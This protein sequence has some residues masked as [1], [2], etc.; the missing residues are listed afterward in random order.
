MYDC[1]GIEISEGGGGAR[2]T[3]TESSRF[4]PLIPPSLRPFPPWC[5]V[6]Q[7]CCCY[8]TVEAACVRPSGFRETPYFPVPF[9]PLFWLL[10]PLLFVLGL[11]IIAD[12]LVLFLLNPRS[13]LAYLQLRRGGQEG[14]VNGTEG[15]SLL[16]LL[17]SSRIA[18]FLPFAAER[19]TS[20]SNAPPTSPPSTSTSSSVS[21][22]RARRRRHTVGARSSTFSTLSSP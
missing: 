10:L 20:P 18:H 3:K 1:S 4:D 8:N 9:Y 5:L 11:R 14:H 6:S 15:L 2:D 7:S 17:S 12:F 21:R 22:K 13:S 16:F 19:I